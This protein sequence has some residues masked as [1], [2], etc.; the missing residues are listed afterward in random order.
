MKITYTGAEASCTVTVDV[1][2]GT[3]TTSRGGAWTI[4]DY[5]TLEELVA[6]VDAD[7]NYAASFSTATGVD[8]VNDDTSPTCLADV[9]AVDI[10]S[11]AY[12]VLELDATRLF[13][14]EI[15]GSKS[16]IEANI[17]G[18]T[19]SALV[20]PLNSYDEIS[21]DA[22]KN[23]GY[24]L[25]GGTSGTNWTL[26]HL[27]AFEVMRVAGSTAPTGTM[28]GSTTATKD[29][30]ALLSWL[31]YVGGVVQI[32]AHGFGAFPRSAWLEV[33]DVVKASGAT[34]MTWNQAAEYLHTHATGVGSISA[35]AETY[36]WCTGTDGNETCFTDVSDYRLLP[37]SICVD[38]G[39]DLGLTKDAAGQ[40][41]P[42]DQGPD[43]GLYEQPDSD[44]DG[45]SDRMELT[46]Y[47]TDPHC[48]DTDGDGLNDRYEV[49]HSP[50]C[51][52]LR[53]LA[54]VDRNG[55][56][57]ATDFVL[58]KKNFQANNPLVDVNRDGYVNS[59]DFALFK[60]AFTTQ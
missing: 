37:T 19:V 47:G 48:R 51:D 57:N 23:A 40:P 25:A 22:V 1:D 4:S 58:F 30:S 24:K 9:T 45:L 13:A 42:V 7:S 18:N 38:A 26:A 35:D 33:L 8:W 49:V 53:N 32:Y 54:D 50:C 6:V 56:I 28:I 43:I 31:G 11:P 36:Y 14:Y 34:V 10:K 5:D 2:G 27:D 59:S 21:E 3:I 46:V 52:P 17:P 29:T 39:T 15:T 12:P 41:V 55:F 16:D 44:G 60:N 20:Y